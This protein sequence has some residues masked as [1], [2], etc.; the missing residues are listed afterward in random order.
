MDLRL[1]V[2]QVITIIMVAP[3]E[4]GFQAMLF[5]SANVICTFAS[6]SNLSIANL[7]DKGKAVPVRIDKL[8]SDSV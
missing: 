8:T 6:M 5:R 1:L 3:N 4:L 2:G 7:S